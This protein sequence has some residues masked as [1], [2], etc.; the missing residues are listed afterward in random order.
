MLET[1]LTHSESTVVDD[2]NTAKTIGS[3]GV[4]VFATPMM[5]ALMEKAARNCV[6]SRLEEGFS[7]VGT[8]VNV[9]HDSASGLGVKITATAELIEID[10]RRL[11]FSVFAE[12]EKGIIGKGIH[13]RFIVDV[14]KFMSKL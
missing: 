1:G 4:N 5:I 14:D 12:D 2:S 3:G 11:V 10:R 6:Q 7:T 9:T 8:L 13:E